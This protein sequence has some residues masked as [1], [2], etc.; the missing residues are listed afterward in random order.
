MGR[1]NPKKA[2]S[3]STT[4][5]EKNQNSSPAQSRSATVA[6]AKEVK[7]VWLRTAQSGRR[8]SAKMNF[9]QFVGTMSGA[10]SAALG[11]VGTT[12]GMTLTRRR[13][14]LRLAGRRMTRRAA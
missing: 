9:T 6:R 13:V 11:L 14:D 1:G 5:R 4:P 8:K 2:I 7:K 3:Q 12:K 10:N